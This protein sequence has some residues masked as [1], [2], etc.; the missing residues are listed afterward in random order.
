MRRHLAPLVV[1]ST[2]CEDT[3]LPLSVRT[4]ARPPG[5]RVIED[6]VEDSSD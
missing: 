5:K 3:W 2:R 4:Q 6:E 1:T